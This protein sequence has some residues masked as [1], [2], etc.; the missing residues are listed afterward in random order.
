M[1]VARKIEQ[2]QYD[3]TVHIDSARGCAISRKPNSVQT[4]AKER[5]CS[6]IL[7]QLRNAQLAAT[8]CRPVRQQVHQ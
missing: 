1:K 6:L 7:G 4:I 2:Q 3:Y 8:A 5:L